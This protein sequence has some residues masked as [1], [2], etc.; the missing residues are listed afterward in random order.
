MNEVRKGLQ[1]LVGAQ[2]VFGHGNQSGSHAQL[3]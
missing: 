1:S 3:T 2:I